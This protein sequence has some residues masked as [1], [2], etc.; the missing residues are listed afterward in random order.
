MLVPERLGWLR[1]GQSSSKTPAIAN[2]RQ[3]AGIR[4]VWYG[5]PDLAHT[6]RTDHKHVTVGSNF[7]FSLRDTGGIGTVR[8]REC[9]PGQ[10]LAAD[11]GSRTEWRARWDHTAA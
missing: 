2:G 11:N 8:H 6:V 5:D 4:P 3:S 10:P 1:H 7:R 9:W